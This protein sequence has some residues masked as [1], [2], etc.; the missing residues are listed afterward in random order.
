MILHCAPLD[1]MCIFHVKLQLLKLF[2]IPSKLIF[3]S[4]SVVFS[5]LGY[6]LRLS[7]HHTLLC[8]VYSIPTSRI[9]ALHSHLALPP[10]A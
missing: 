4:W 8:L 6:A 3:Q 9:F 7:F 1:H 2:P 10:T 5:P